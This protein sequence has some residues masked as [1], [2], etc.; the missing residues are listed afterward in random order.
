MLSHVREEVHILGT[1]CEAGLLLLREF[2][3]TLT[4]SGWLVSR[5]S[6]KPCV[7]QGARGCHG[8]LDHSP[9]VLQ[10]SGQAAAASQTLSHSIRRSSELGSPSLVSFCACFAHPTPCRNQARGPHG[11]P[12][13]VVTGPC[14]PGAFCVG[15]LLT[16]GLTVA[17]LL[18]V[19]VSTPEANAR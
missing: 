13:T 10:G 12:R 14:P 7:G 3:N 4:R 11:K 19:E 5:R 2:V 6:R 9:S 18:Y 17:V 16:F 8:G 1:L 15:V